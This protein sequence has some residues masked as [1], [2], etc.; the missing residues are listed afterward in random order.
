MR[1]GASRGKD[2]SPSHCIF[3]PKPPV[4]ALAALGFSA[5]SLRPTQPSCCPITAQ[6]QHQ[7]G[8]LK[9]FP[10]SLSRCGPTEQSP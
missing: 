5:L 2:L 4:P 8:Q 9:G 6:A 7:S 1:E 3:Q 10:T